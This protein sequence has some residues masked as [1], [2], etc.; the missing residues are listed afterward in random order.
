MDQSNASPHYVLYIVVP[1]LAV[2]AICMSLPPLIWHFKNRNLAATTMIF[3][4]LLQ[5]VMYLINSLIWSTDDTETWWDGTGLCDIEVKLYI[6]INTGIISAL[7]AV[8]RN[9]ANVLDRDRNTIIP[10]QA[11]RRRALAIDLFLCFGIPSYLMIIHYVVQPNRYYIFTIAGC[12]PSYSYS[13]VSLLLMWIWG[14]ILSL[15]AGFYSVLVMVRVQRHHAELS[16]MLRNSNT[17]LNKSRF[18]RLF[19]LS[20]SIVV[21][22][23]PVDWYVLYT[24]ISTGLGS[25][26]WSFVHGSEW[27]QIP[28]VPQ[29]G[30]IPFWVWIPLASGIVVFFFFGIGRD[31]TTMYRSWLSKL[32]LGKLFPG[33]N[34]PY[35]PRKT[36]NGSALGNFFDSV[37]SRAKLL[38][39]KSTWQ[40]SSFSSTRRLSSPFSTIASATTS[41]PP[42][43]DFS[44]ISNDIIGEGKAS[45]S[46]ASWFNH[47]ITELIFLRSHMFA[48]QR[49]ENGMQLQNQPIEQPST[50]VTNIQIG[51]PG[52]VRSDDFGVR[53]ERSIEQSQTMQV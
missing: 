41:S 6:A 13:W 2:V 21:L 52:P 14:P 29:N 19:I 15:V 35:T 25:Y 4:I 42:Q 20:I 1:V 49:C 27:N 53:V 11:Q 10:T 28:K 45:L 40:R 50:V 47:L 46:R 51:S 32:G 16:G 48:R 24:F 26:S 36:S 44:S 39:R 43:K 5:N 3:W 34:R 38:Y 30:K 7:V 18:L 22:I 37:G 17:N 12:L 9:L 33:L 23:L 31:A 8:M